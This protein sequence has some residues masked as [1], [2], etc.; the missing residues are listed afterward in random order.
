M[1]REAHSDVC[2]TQDTGCT[3]TLDKNQWI[4]KAMGYTEQVPV[5]ADVMFA[6]LACGAD[7]YKIVQLQWHTTDWRPCAKR[8]E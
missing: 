8:S 2:I 4:G 5:M 1:V 7:V 3:T 6:A